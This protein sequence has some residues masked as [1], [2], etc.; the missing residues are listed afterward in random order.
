[1]ELKTF[2]AQTL[3]ELCEG[4]SDAQQRVLDLGARV[5]PALVAGN[6]TKVDFD[7]EVS[8]A[9]GA[10]AKSGLG[11]FVGAISAGA[12]GQMEAKQNSVGRIRFTVPVI[13]PV[14]DGNSRKRIQG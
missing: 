6:I 5:N 13:M 11:V 10:S 12:Q 14:T 8:T 4:V 7:V 3:V 2:I 1:M 9:E